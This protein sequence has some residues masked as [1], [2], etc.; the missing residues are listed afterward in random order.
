MWLRLRQ[1]GTSILLFAVFPRGTRR[2]GKPKEK[3]T[4]LPKAKKHI[5]QMLADRLG[6]RLR[7]FPRGES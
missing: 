1:H 5:T 7:S 2:N 3:R 4:A 6:W